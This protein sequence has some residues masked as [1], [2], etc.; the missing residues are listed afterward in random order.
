MKVT[1]QK[2]NQKTTHYCKY[3]LKL[4]K[5]FKGLFTEKQA[6]LQH[7]L[8]FGFI[9]RSL[10]PKGKMQNLRYEDTNETFSPQIILKGKN[11]SK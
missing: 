3:L 6:G 5:I 8:F 10:K 4:N 9:K 7:M 11:L 2:K 1:P